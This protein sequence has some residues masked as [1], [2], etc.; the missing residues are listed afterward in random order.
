[1]FAA[2]PYSCVPVASFISLV[3]LAATGSELTT[4]NLFMVLAVFKT[5]RVTLSWYV[6]RA[7][8]FMADVLAALRR[9]QVLLETQ[10]LQQLSTKKN[11]Y[12][13]EITEQ[14][15]TSTGP[16][17]LQQSTTAFSLQNVTCSWNGEGTAPTLKSVSLEIPRSGLVLVTGPVGCG[18]SSLILA[19]LKELPLIQGTIS[20]SGKI[21]YVSPEP[22]IFGGTVRENILFGEELQDERYSKVIEACA[23][24]EDMESFPNG[25][26]T[27][28]GERGTFLS[29]GQRSRV[30]LARAV[31]ADA[32]IYLLDNP[33]SAVDAKVGNHIFQ[34]CICGVLSQRTRLLVTDGLQYD[35]N[36]NHIIVMESGL[37]VRDEKRTAMS[38]GSF[39][40]SEQRIPH[41]SE[42]SPQDLSLQCKGLEL[43]EEDRATGSVNVGFYW[44]Y[45]R[46]GFCS[47]SV[48]ML[49]IF[50]P[51]VQG[52]C[53]QK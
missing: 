49:L 24:L 2:L 46:A 47:S 32:E 27:L 15:F 6:A 45:L 31:Y 22:W 3:T 26:L 4:Y 12:S 20:C 25:D 35:Q 8:V 38:Q 21:A 1:M 14:S 53:L 28:I 48:M 13:K 39:C 11:C 41:K 42:H 44:R 16:D 17:T 50:F 7:V 51:I 40:T 18:K 29:G 5:L 19:I 33:L 52:K 43:T 10:E 23:L 37:V 9:I 36:A 30:S 34:K